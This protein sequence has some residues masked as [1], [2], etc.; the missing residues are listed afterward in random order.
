MG[1]LLV[2]DGL[3]ERIEPLLPVHVPKPW[4]GRPAVPNRI[5]L[6]G[7]LLV[8]L[9]GIPWEDLPRNA[10]PDPDVTPEQLSCAPARV[11]GQ[12]CDARG[13]CADGLSCRVHRC[14]SDPPAAAGS[15]CPEE[16]D[17]RSD[18]YCSRS[19]STFDVRSEGVCAA[20]KPEGATCSSSLQCGGLC[21]EGTCAAFCGAH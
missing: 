9:T 10:T 20:R 2:P 11:A 1:K 14:S 21:L 6:T 17:C 5:A 16:D 13:A 12:R 15:A 8:L 19:Q 18:L 7:I 3:W 4:G